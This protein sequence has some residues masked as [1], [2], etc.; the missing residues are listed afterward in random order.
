MRENREERGDLEER[1]PEIV[2]KI[3][4]AGFKAYY[5]EASAE[6]KIDLAPLMEEMQGAMGRMGRRR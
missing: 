6:T 1:D 5:T 4:E 3:A 2:E